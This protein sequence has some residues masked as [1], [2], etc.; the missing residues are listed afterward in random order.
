MPKIRKA[1]YERGY[2][3]TLMGGGITGYIQAND[4]DLHK[5]LKALYREDEMRLMLKMLEADKSK[6]P[7]PNRENR[8]KILMS[9]WDAITTDFSLVFKKLFVT[10]KLGGSEDYLVSDKRFF[11]SEI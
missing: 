4:A 9:S 6:I 2:T 3:L 7:F 8:I 5:R 1:L 11:G 10:N